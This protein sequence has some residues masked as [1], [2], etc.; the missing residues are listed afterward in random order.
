[1]LLVD[2]ELATA[3]PGLNADGRHRLPAPLTAADVDALHALTRDPDHEAWSARWRPVDVPDPTPSADGPD[4]G[5]VARLPL[6]L[7]PAV[8]G[9][10]ASAPGGP[11]RLRPPHFVALAAFLRPRSAED[12]A[13]EIGPDGSTLVAELV[14]AGLLVAEA[15]LGGVFDSGARSRHR[16]RS[17]QLRVRRSVAG[18]DALSAEDG[19]IPVVGLVTSLSD[20]PL[21]LGM[22]LARAA[23]SPRLADRFSFHLVY[24]TPADLAAV[25]RPGVWLLSNYL[26]T[27]GRNIKLA[28]ALADAA[29]PHLAV[30]GGPQVPDPLAAPAWMEAARTDVAVHGEGEATL[31]AL[32][33]ALPDQWEDTRA[34]LAD[35]HVAGATVRGPSGARWGGERPRLADLDEL[36]SPFLEGWFDD[37]GG[38][39]FYSAVLETNRGCP[40]A[41]TFCDWGSATRSRIRTFALDRVGEEIDWIAAHGYEH[42]LLADANFGILER[43]REIAARLVAARRRHGRPI[44]LGTNYAKNP[45]RHVVDIV[46]D[47]VEAGFVTI[48]QVALQTVDKATLVAVERAN[49]APESY[50]DLLRAFDAL[51]LPIQTDLMMG[52]PGATPAAF[53]ADLQH[54]V[55]SDVHAIVARTKVLR[56][57]PMNA[58]DH[59]RRFAIQTAGDEFILATST[60]DEGDLDEMIADHTAFFA[61]DDLGVLRLVA[62]FVRHRSGLAEMDLVTRM[63]TVTGSHPDRYPTLAWV[64]RTLARWAVEPV[65]WS[66]LLDEARAFVV[67]ELGL[68]DDTALDAVLAAQA[69]VLPAPGRRLPVTVALDHDVA[70]WWNDLK[71]A[72]RAGRPWAE[73]PDLGDHGPGALTVED[74]DRLCDLAMGDLALM[75]RSP[76]W[77]L[78]SAVGRASPGGLL[79]T[80]G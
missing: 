63:R 2:D 42:L 4:G 35:V 10:A 57:A 21:S 69:A 16:S 60:F 26:W 79:V 5:L 1:V 76:A 59:R 49:I 72:R 77:D 9:F 62:R 23:A 70:T 78:R 80:A 58:P 43:D 74:P 6:V 27:E 22:V 33:A 28:T 19:R 67:D 17:R 50:D 20:F 7:G 13:A 73:V 56:N 40:Y 32:L 71:A 25:R 53:R 44:V 68:D 24:A 47:L 48:G 64:L 65:A 30:F 41:C 46:A 37:L 29:A 36:P 55:D 61:V 8:D 52:L 66:R 3:T 18:V 12:G 38:D 45:K 15:S 54:V 14:G 75:G 39:L 31:E 11:V 51:G 34:A